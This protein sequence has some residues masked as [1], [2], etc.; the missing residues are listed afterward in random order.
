MDALYNV[1]IWSAGAAIFFMSLIIPWGIFARYV[2]GSGSQWPEP[3]S[4]LL[5]VVFTFV[6]AAASYRAGSHIAVAMVTD[7]LPPALRR[8]AA[9]VVH[10]V[11]LL[12][13][14]FMVVYGV[15]LCR[16]TWGQ[17]IPDLPW[18]PVGFSYL[19][20]PIG[21][22]FTLLFVLE[23]MGFGPQNHRAIVRFDHDID[24]GEGAN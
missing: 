22:L 23:H 7:R 3:V 1:C 4:I 2:L 6:G 16:E 20:V 24:H 15:K 17:T 14:L 21:G 8:F 18:M 13:A 11:M 5:M 10:A 19:P 12:L 9:T